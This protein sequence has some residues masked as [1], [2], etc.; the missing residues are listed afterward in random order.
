MVL[1][2]LGSVVHDARVIK[3]ATSLASQG[4]EVRLVAMR[5]EGDRAENM[6]RNFGLSLFP[7]QTRNWPRNPAVWLLKYFEFNAKALM[8]MIDFRADA[9][10]AHD[11]DTLIPA[12]LAA[13]FTGAFLV[14]DAHE[15]YADRPVEVPWLWRALERFLIHRADRVIAA[16]EDRAEIMMQRHGLRVLPTVLMNCPVR[17]APGQVVGRTLRDDLPPHLRK[18]RILLYQGGLSPNRCLESLIQSV[19]HL[20]PEVALVFLGSPNAFKDQILSRLVRELGIE[21]RVAFLKAV[22]SRDLVDYIST[23]DLGVVIY[24]NSC[25]NNYLCAPNK[26]FDYAMAGLPS[27]GC[28][29]PPIRR[30]ADRFGTTALFNPEDPASIASA[31]HSLLRHPRAYVAAKEA[32]RALSLAYSWEQEE[33]KLAM[34]YRSL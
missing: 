9:Y 34:M 19:P 31:A 15:L 29:F 23:A 13:R 18:S 33:E 21:N 30:V 3:E 24:K 1:M 6:V 14:Y 2:N 27:L 4:H 26:L 25:L 5:H 11:L 10:H 32:T 17:S 16:N 22:D 7:L 8:R 20:D 12:W 28:D